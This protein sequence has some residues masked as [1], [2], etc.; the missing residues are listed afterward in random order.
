MSPGCVMVDLKGTDLLPEERELLAHPNVGGII[1]FTRNYHDRAQLA[2]LIRSVR[3]VR[4]ALLIAVD[5]EGGRV[6]RFRDGFTELPPARRLGALAAVDFG[7]ARRRATQFGGL[8]AAELRAL[9]IDFS[10]A[11]VLDL[12]LGISGV[13]G[14]RALHFDPYVVAELGKAIVAG[15]RDL[16]MPAVGKHFPGHGGVAA[17]SHTCQPEDGRSFSA[18]AAN[19]LIPFQRLVAAGIPA[20]MPAHV[21]YPAVDGAPAGFSRYWLQTVLREQCRFTGAI[22]SDDLSMV[23]ATTVVEPVARA[24]SALAAGCDLVLLCNQPDTAAK[25]VEQLT[26]P[27]DPVAL[28]RRLS[29][30][31][32]RSRDVAFGRDWPLWQAAHAALDV[33]AASNYVTLD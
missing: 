29:L 18:L 13:I 5:H 22:V 25:V 16:G 11:P 27:M 6:Q 30:R 4:E 20:I 19:D 9:D 1:L 10:F 31:A 12:D 24:E 15:M 2:E 28:Q 33:S 14:D 23:A 3:Q 21:R 7:L 26:W 32:D 17:D 8:I